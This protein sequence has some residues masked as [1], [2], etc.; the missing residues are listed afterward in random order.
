LSDNLPLWNESAVALKAPAA[1]DL[2]PSRPLYDGSLGELYAIYLRHIV[3]MLVTFGWSRFWGRTRLR[4]YVWNHLSILGDRFEYR[5]RGRELLFGFLLA[6]VMLAAW[7]GLM[8]LVWLYVFHEKPFASFGLFDIFSLSV[9]VIGFPLAYV[10]HY[11]GLRYKLSRT[12]WRGIRC[13]MAGSAWRYGVIAT[14][15][16]FAN[17]MTGQLLTPVVSVNL[18]RPRIS[19][20]RVGTLPL[21]FAGS[22]GDIYGRFL[23]YYFLNIVG[24]LVA[25][26]AAFAIVGGTVSQLGVTEDDFLKLLTQPTMRTILLIVAALVGLYVVFSLLILPLRCWWQAY[27]F[28]YLVSHTRADNVLFATAITTWQMWGFLVLNYLIVVFT[29]GLGWPWVMHRTLRL[30]SGQL[31]IYGAPDGGTIAQPPDRGPGFGEGLLDMF[32]VSGI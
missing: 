19:N 31:W 3:M 16:V 11:A 4:R 20:A 14:F 23:G 7:I 24:W 12:R 25:I 26:G 30:I 8:Y 28:R 32:D 15:L 5:G 6:V 17:A 29:L 18:A 21:A 27:L 9:L 13:G 2:T 10:G 22:A 1:P